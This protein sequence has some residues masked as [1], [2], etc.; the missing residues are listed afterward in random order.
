MLNRENSLIICKE[1]LKEIYNDLFVHMYES[2]RVLNSKLIRI[3]DVVKDIKD[4]SKNKWIDRYQNIAKK[5]HD[6]D[7]EQA[8]GEDRD[9]IYELNSQNVRNKPL[10]LEVYVIGIDASLKAG[11]T[12]A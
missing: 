10:S 11:N 2:C 3:G 5:F 8:N 6:E 1:P 9:F 12:D 4:K 7:Y